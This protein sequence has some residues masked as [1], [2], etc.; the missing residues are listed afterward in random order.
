MVETQHAQ[1]KIAKIDEKQGRTA[2]MSTSYRKSV[3]LN[4]FS[5]RYSQP[6]VELMHLLR[7]RK[8]YRHKSRRKRRRQANVIHLYRKTG[9]QNLNMML[10]YKPEVRYHLN[11]HAEWKIDQLCD[12][13]HGTGK[14]FCVMEE[15]G[16]GESISGD[17]FATRCRIYA[18]ADII[19][20]F[21]THDIR[22]TPSSLSSLILCL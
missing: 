11:W 10:D 16:V 14:I 13:L 20:M 8:R 15:T 5:V 17:K 22:Q 19:V 3:L 6:E 9:S 7:M 18:C 12:K 4:P 1:W 2:T 21:D